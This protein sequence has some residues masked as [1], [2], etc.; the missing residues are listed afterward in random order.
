MSCFR[1]V[2]WPHHLACGSGSQS[3]IEH[4]PPAVEAWR[5]NCWT[6]RGIQKFSYFE[7]ECLESI[8]LTVEYHPLLP[9]SLQI[10][11]EKSFQFAIGL[12]GHQF[13]TNIKC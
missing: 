2:F 4:V 12:E 9:K 1:F 7:W 8:A 10:S 11:P 6:A 13:T 5:V 3:E